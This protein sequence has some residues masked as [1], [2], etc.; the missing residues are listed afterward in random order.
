MFYVR[1]GADP[2]VDVPPTEIK[3][4]G[5]KREFNVGQRTC[6]PEQLDVLKKTSYELWTWPTSNGILR[7]N[8]HASHSS[9]RRMVLKD[10]AS[11]LTSARATVR[12]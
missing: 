1:L 5:P 4:E 12:P 6:S 9:F 11:Q 2:P 10:F 7:R 3:F 8:V